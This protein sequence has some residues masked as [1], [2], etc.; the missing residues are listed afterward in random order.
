MKRAF[1]EQAHRVSVDD[2]TPEDDSSKLLKRSKVQRELL[3]SRGTME[4]ML[5]RWFQ[6]TA[7]YRFGP[8]F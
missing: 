8:D 4:K 1:L 2:E 5:F 3:T 7:G 6:L